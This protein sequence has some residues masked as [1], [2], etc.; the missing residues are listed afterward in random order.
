VAQILKVAERITLALLALPFVCI[1]LYALPA[2]AVTPFSGLEVA[3]SEKTPGA[4]VFGVA[5][6]SPASLAGVQ[7]GDVIVSIEGQ[8]IKSLEDFVNFSQTIK[9]KGKAA[10]TLDRQ[11]KLYNVVLGKSPAKQE[12]AQSETAQSVAG[13]V[14][15]QGGALGV[16]IRGGALV[17]DVVPGSAAEKAGIRKGDLIVEFNGMEIATFSDLPQMV[18]A[19]APGTRAEVKIVREGGVKNLQ[20][21]LGKREQM[22]TAAPHQQD[23]K[24]PSVPEEKKEQPSDN[25][26]LPDDLGEL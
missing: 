5:P 26:S 4:R 23:R 13:T 21:I 12:Q 8:G 3:N 18:A 7:P 10:L 2:H 25:I 11:G 14:H 6:G 1:S 24:E 20:V 16:L 9:G 19:L 22:P 15:D 17:I